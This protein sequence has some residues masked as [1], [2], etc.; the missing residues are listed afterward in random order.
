M[1]ENANILAQWLKGELTEAEEEQ[2]AKDYDLQALKRLTDATAELEMPAFDKA[3]AWERF[4]DRVGWEE[5]TPDARIRI[6]PYRWLGMAVAASIVLGLLFWLAQPQAETEI[7][8]PIAS[9]QTLSLPDGSEVS[10]NAD[11]RLSY[12]E[13]DWE[14]KRIVYLEGEAFF[15]VKKGESFIVKTPL[16]EVEVLGTSFNVKMRQDKMETRCFTGKV[17]VS[18]K[19]ATAEL[20]PGFG[21]EIENRAL[22]DLYIF[23]NTDMAEP[24]WIHGA[25]SYKQA[26]FSEVVAELERQFGLQ[27][28]YPDLGDRTYSGGYS[29]NASLENALKLVTSPMGLSYE[30]KDE[31]HIVFRYEE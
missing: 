5:A 21:V 11:S 18:N 24:G 31:Q 4:A 19:Q 1:T 23:P 17:K 15:R 9:Q 14:K 20:E 28:D 12:Q 6:F 30:I 13:G 26:D 29:K 27:I 22:K 7:Y 10:L 16:G 3:Q 8:V 2:L 25:F